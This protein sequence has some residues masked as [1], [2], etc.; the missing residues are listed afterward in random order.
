MQITIHRGIN[1]IGG[2]IN[3]IA[4]EKARIIIDLGQNLPDNDGNNFDPFDSKDAIE[5]LCNGVDA[6]FY[7]HYHGDH[8]GHFHSI[9]DKV[10]QY[11]GATAQ[12]IALRKYK[13]LSLIPDKKAEMERAM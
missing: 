5:K 11:I 9:P 1:Q 4:T 12:K 2:C 13:Q 7:T 3:E 8:F 10:K 6:I